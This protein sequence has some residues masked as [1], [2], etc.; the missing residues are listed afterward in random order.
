MSLEELLDEV[1][2]LP[3]GPDLGDALLQ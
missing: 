3:P 2:E 1:D